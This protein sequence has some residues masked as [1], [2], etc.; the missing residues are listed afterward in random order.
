MNAKQAIVIAAVA[1]V[2][3]TAIAQQQDLSIYQPAIPKST[4]TR[5]E[6]RAEFL[7]ARADGRLPESSESVSF[8]RNAAPSTLTREQ[9]KAELAQARANGS[10]IQATELALIIGEP[11]VST[12]SREEVRAEALEVTRSRV[13]RKQ[14]S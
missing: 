4:L 7:K 11:I 13:S 3:S 10:L 1:F 2:S 14:G 8:N 6:V 5:E 9:V 12:R